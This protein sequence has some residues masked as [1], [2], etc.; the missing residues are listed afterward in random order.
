[1][2]KKITIAVVCAV[3]SCVC[4]IG[5]TFAWLVD[6]T[7]PVEN[8]F[9]VGNVDI[10][11]TESDDLDLKMVPGNDITKDPKVIVKA[12]SEDCYVFVKVEK[13]ANFDDFMTYAKADGWDEYKTEDNYVVYSR[14]V[15]LQ[16]TDQEF[17]ILADNKVSV[18]NSVTKGMMDAIKAGTST[19]PTLTFTAY[20]AQKSNLTIDEAWAAINA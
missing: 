18:K 16:D 19:S 9:T 7:D 13:S 15:S 4:L 6:K 8:T 1:M 20:A 11:L 12:N 3:L 10:E 14:T 2:K 17:A 5:T